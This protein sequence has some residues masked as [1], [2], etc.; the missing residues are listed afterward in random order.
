[1]ATVRTF[2]AIELASEIRTGLGAL[3]ARLAQGAGGV[4]G[5]WVKP[6]GIHLTLKFLDRKSVV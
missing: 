2:L 6:E 4:A 1:M 3:Q 5:R